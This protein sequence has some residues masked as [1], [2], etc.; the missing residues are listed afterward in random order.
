MRKE[1]CP[2]VYKY[3]FWHSGLEFLLTADEMLLVVADRQ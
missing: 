2:P 3:S 1:M